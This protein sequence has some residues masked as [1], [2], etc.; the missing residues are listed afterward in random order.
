MAAKILVVDKVHENLV[1]R[2]G[3]Q[4]LECEVNREL[5]YD[6]FIALPDEY[7]GLIIRSRFVVDKK[8]LLSKPSLRFVVRIGSGVESI[9]TEFAERCGVKV[10]STPEGNAPSVAEHALGL[11]L[12]ALR[13]TAAADKEVRRGEWLREKNKGCEIGSR[14]VG[15]IGYGH[16]GPAF[17]RLLK[18][19]G[20]QIYAYDKFK[21]GF[22]SADVTE[23]PLETL[24]EKCDVLSL[25]INYMPENHYFI[26]KNIINQAK[27]P[28]V[29]INTS[30]GLAVNTADVVGGL[31]EGKI[32][33]VCLDV[34]EYEDVRLKNA[35][36]DD[37]QEPMRQLAEM[38]NVILTPHIA[39]QTTDAERRHA[40]VAFEKIMQVLREL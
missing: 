11:L 2:L 16:T 35:P 18:P 36:Q 21:T 5:T 26:N 27:H 37:W 9:D 28:F 30:R 29:F 7:L 25:H 3:E 34:L 13:H 39:G 15:I 31:K 14:T 22:G 6:D 12:A 24:L 1:A 40:E 10:L 33:C 17:A 19:F 32:Q 4:G 20:C 38:E 8:A 23:A